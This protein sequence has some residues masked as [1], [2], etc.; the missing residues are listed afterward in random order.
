MLEGPGR[1][2]PGKENLYGAI[3]RGW[4]VAARSITH[5]GVGMILAGCSSQA[6]DLKAG[7]WE[8]TSE[9]VSLMGIAPR[10]GGPAATLTIKH[11]LTAHEARRPNAHFLVGEPPDSN[12]AYR[13]F[14]MK[15]GRVRGSV[16]CAKA[17]MTLRTRIEGTYRLSSF[18][19]VMSGDV[20]KNNVTLATETRS[21]GRRIGQCRDLK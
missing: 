15:D 20:T 8:I 19:T 17:G 9:I 2:F 16:E 13:D 10:H 12:C 3:G 4:E 14:T 6:D 7:E 21:R 1:S 11:C 18:E 5:L